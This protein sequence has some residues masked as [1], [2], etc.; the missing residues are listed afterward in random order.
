MPIENKKDKER[1][2]VVST[3]GS[4]EVERQ[5]AETEELLRNTR[6]L[7]DHLADGEGETRRHINELKESLEKDL[8]RLETERREREGRDGAGNLSRPK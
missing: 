8:R 2:G 7:L 4:P 6:A 1:M 5:I 3:E